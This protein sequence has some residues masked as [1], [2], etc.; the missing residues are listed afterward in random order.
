MFVATGPNLDLCLDW[1]EFLVGSITRRSAGKSCSKQSTY[2]SFLINGFYPCL[3]VMAT[4]APSSR[5]S[6]K[7]C[8]GIKSHVDV[9]PVEYFIINGSI[10]GYLMLTSNAKLWPTGNNCPG[11]AEETGEEDENNRRVNRVG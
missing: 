3:W 2:F 7:T 10:L 9:L 1:G 6:L 5:S 8:A 11:V 4:R